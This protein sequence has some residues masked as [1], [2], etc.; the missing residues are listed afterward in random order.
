MEFIEGKT[1]KELL[2]EWPEKKFTWQE[3]EPIAT[4]I[5]DALDYAHSVVY[6]DTINREV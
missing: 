3:L 1:L 4:Q 5:A 2:A 6:C